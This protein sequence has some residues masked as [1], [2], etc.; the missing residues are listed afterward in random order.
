MITNIRITKQ[1]EFLKKLTRLNRLSHAYLFSGNDRKQK[2]EIMSY[3]LDVLLIQDADQI[4]I[5]PGKDES[6]LEITIAH[7]R[8]LSSFLSMS[9]WNSPYKVAMMYDA[10]F[11]NKEAQSAFLKLLEEPKG[12]TLFFLHSEYP[13]LLLNTIRSR[14]QEFKFYSF[15]Y[16]TD[17]STAEEFERLRKSDLGFRFAAAKTLADSRS[18]IAEKLEHWLII[19]RRLLLEAIRNDP[20]EAGKL[21]QTIKALQEV[22]LALQTSNV[23]P[24]LALERLMLDF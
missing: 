11:M 1:Y 6:A 15:A 8:T 14:V 16:E 2:E 19:A 13:D 5:R 12:E 10:H 9:P 17:E 23:N 21:L 20:A 7:I 18:E 4:T 24:R 3:I 22:S